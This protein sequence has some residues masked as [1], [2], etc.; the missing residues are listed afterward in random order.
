MQRK[1]T[2]VHLAK[3]LRKLRDQTRDDAIVYLK[4]ILPNSSKFVSLISE[5]FE[6][7]E[8][9]DFD[10]WCDMIAFILAD[11]A[12]YRQLCEVLL[13]TSWCLLSRGKTKQCS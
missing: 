12:G 8:A 4:G 10:Q 13:K 9:L 7:Y 2:N 3:I 5:Y 11:T 6:Y 1:L